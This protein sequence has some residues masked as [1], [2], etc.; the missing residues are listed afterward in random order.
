MLRYAAQPVAEEEEGEPAHLLSNNAPAVLTGAARP[1]AQEISTLLSG[2]R[3]R[4][5]DYQTALPNFVCLLVT[6]RFY[7]KTGREDWKRHDNITELL[8]YASGQEDYTTLEVNGER[9]SA[10][11]SKIGGVQAKGEF[12]PFLQAVFSK[13]ANANFEWQGTTDLDGSP[14]EVFRYSV[15]KA[16]SIYTLKSEDGPKQATV[17]FHGFVYIEPNTLAVR[18]VSIEAEDIPIDFSWR[19]SALDV[20]YNYVAVGEQE[21]LLPLSATLRLR[22]GKKMILKNEMQFREYKRFAASSRLVPQ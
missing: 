5:L 19:E 10:D 7:D 11:R 20:R 16:R 13:E 3:N 4:A 6:E 9:V 14:V 17:G 12:G 15:P 18:R 2:V 8:R 1:S 22:K 21:Y